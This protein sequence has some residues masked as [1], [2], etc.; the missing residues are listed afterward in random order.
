MKDYDKNDRNTHVIIG[1]FT[2]KGYI[3]QEVNG[4]TVQIPVSKLKIIP[5]KGGTAAVTP[6]TN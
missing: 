2:P 5:P 1:G 3:T 6:K 4:K